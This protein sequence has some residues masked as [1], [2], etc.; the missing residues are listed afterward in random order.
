MGT[1]NPQLWDVMEVRQQNHRLDRNY[2]VING[3]QGMPG[4]GAAPGG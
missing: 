2:K 1:K 4:D 3:F